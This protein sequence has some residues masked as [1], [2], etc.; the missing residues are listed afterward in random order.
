VRFAFKCLAVRHVN[1]RVTLTPIDFPDLAVH[2][3]DLE[4]ATEELVL[5]LDD[6]IARAHP[7]RVVEYA[8]PAG[9]DPLPI[10]MPLV[11]VWDGH[12]ETVAPLRVSGLRA[13]AHQPYLE[14]RV[15][16]LDLR[17]WLPDG[18]AG[19]PGFVA[20]ATELVR[21]H[22]QTLDEDDL[23]AL[24][25]EGEESFLEVAVEVTPLRLS[26]L[27]RRELHLDERPATAAALARRRDEGGDA[28]DDTGQPDEEGLGGDE[29]ELADGGDDQDDDDDWEE[30]PRQRKK[31]KR[32]AVG[33]KPRKVATP[34]LD[35]LG[36]P[37]HR[38]AR[39]G[40]LD[41]AFERDALVAELR[42][43]LVRAADDREPREAVVLVGPTGAGKSAVIRELCRA[44][45]TS[46]PPPGEA[47]PPV[48]LI[49]GGRL[50]AGEGFS[51][52]WQAQALAVLREAREARAILCVGHVLELLDAGKSAQSE[53]NVAQLLMPVLAAREISL[54]AE[55]TTEEWARV[56]G[57]NAGFSRLWS[58]VRVDDP[59]PEI[60]R[61]ILVRVAEELGLEHD[62][63]FAPGVVPE[64]LSLCARFRPYGALVGNAASFL[65][66]LAGARDKSNAAHLGPVDALDAVAAFAA[67]C[68][69][70]EKLLRDD[71]PLD[72]PAI[73]A[74]LEGRVKGQPAAVERVAS[75]VSVI[76]A[77]LAD[78]KRPAAVLLFAGP[79]G[80]GKTELCKALGEVVFGDR[81][82]LVRLDM[83]EYGG[84]DGL[85][86]LIGGDG[87]GHLTSAVRRQPFSVIL[88]DE[89][90]KAHPAVFDALLGVLGE[91]RLTD[92]RG[93]LTDFRSTVFVLT[94]NIGADTWRAS[95]GFLD[96]AGAGAAA[97]H[98]R[99][100]VRRFF[101]PELYNR[102]DDVVVFSPLGEPEI[103]RI[104]GREL[105]RVAAREGLRRR[106]VDLAVDEEGRRLLAARGV[107]ARYGARPLRRVIE[108]QLVAP[109]AEYL[110]AHPPRGAVRL[111]ASAGEAG[112]LLHAESLGRAEAPSRAAIRRL[113]A[114]AAAVR[115]EIGRW[116]RS[117]PMT[118]VRHDVALFDRESHHPAFWDE[119]A[120][121][122]ERARAVASGR[123]LLQAFESAR[124]LA[125][126]AEDLAY[127][128][129]FT[130][131]AQAVDSLEAD[132]G[133]LEAEQAALAERVYLSLFPRVGEA[134]LIL[135]PGR[136][137]WADAVWLMHRYAAWVQGRGGSVAVTLARP[138]EVEASAPAARPGQ[139]AQPAPA[140]AA[141]RKAEGPIRWKAEK[142][143]PDEEDAPPV[144]AA[145]S[146]SGF[147]AVVLLAGEHGAHRFTSSGATSLVRVRFE[148]RARRLHGE[149]RPD[150]WERL[151]PTTEV[152]RI[153]R[154]DKEI[155]LDLGMST[156]YDISGRA[157]IDELLADYLHFRV[158]GTARP[159]GPGKGGR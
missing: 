114:R 5:A 104:I 121:A 47:A 143:L 140:R 120:L 39:R 151:I 83:G 23:L 122:E 107:D 130:R 27:K 117:G 93:R 71:V 134:T 46:P 124:A 88:L 111:T 98:Y 38:L 91:G 138:A 70:P 28:D 145:L 92:G 116:S 12:G 31:K 74:F 146:C 36:T 17:F 78:R 30:D 33:K 7:R 10:E 85:A 123:E 19:A 64:V 3:V 144:A 69:V 11:R 82:R 16:R 58:V 127:E 108:R 129:Y 148:A 101:R 21:A 53:Q 44:L 142:A 73:R 147:P 62:L 158:F 13:P 2:A 24:R 157:E 72:P 54:L 126:A 89:I 55:A 106:E 132:L 25:S 119:R 49:D 84:A 90:E 75:V 113:L 40:E 56:E 76:K 77:N 34:T 29:R 152:R 80:V 97:A 141:R 155:L 52:D 102:L 32:A 14:L 22:L 50:I 66:R 9:G 60:A 48:F 63:A 35:R 95:A 128:A 81:D 42:G 41:P 51:G 59:A 105:E 109:V 115:A 4:R 79:T 67:E 100:E 149:Y 150:E 110:A 6:K 133:A 61:R 26:D 139:P 20:E 103:D 118:R 136:G 15:P 87:L 57:R 159:G 1:R 137:G 68:G 43:R 65:R 135:W 18:K 131:R 45:L 156:R 112:I 99:A 153:W 8:R 94:S 86:R 96:T 37:L 125:E 154:D